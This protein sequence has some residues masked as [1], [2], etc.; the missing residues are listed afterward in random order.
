MQQYSAIGALPV[1][2]GVWFGTAHAQPTAPYP[3]GPIRLAVRVPPRGNVD[4]LARVLVKQL[5]EAAA[6]PNRHRR[7]RGR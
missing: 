3:A 6:A 2:F 7:S 4:T 1:T 5:K